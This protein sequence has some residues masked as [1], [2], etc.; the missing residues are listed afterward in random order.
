MGPAWVPM[1]DTSTSPILS[2]DYITCLTSAALAP[3]RIGSDTKLA[4]WTVKKAGLLA[5]IWDRPANSSF[6]T[7]ANSTGMGSS[8]HPDDSRRCRSPYRAVERDFASMRYRRGST[9]SNSSPMLN[10]YEY[11]GDRPP[12][13]RNGASEFEKMLWLTAMLQP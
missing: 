1:L 11:A 4:I 2:R 3:T 9:L 10:R 13:A 8:A 12:S 7:L 6:W 5:S